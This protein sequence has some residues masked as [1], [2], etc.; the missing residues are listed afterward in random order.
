MR[1]ATLTKPYQ[2]FVLGALL[3]ATILTV[4]VLA[5]RRAYQDKTWPPLK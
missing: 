5:L 2:I 4:F 1:S 3:N